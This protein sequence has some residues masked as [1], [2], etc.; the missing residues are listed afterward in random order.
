VVTEGKPTG[1][2]TSLRPCFI[3]LLNIFVSSSKF[4]IIGDHGLAH[5]RLDPFHATP[6]PESVMLQAR[7]PTSLQG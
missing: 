6:F 4:V 7:C 1:Y 3:K 5:A 2:F